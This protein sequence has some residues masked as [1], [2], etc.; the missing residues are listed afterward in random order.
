MK[1][2]KI[3]ILKKKHFIIGQKRTER[4]MPLGSAIEHGHFASVHTDNPVTPI[5]SFRPVKAAIT[6][7][8]RT[9]SQVIGEHEK[10]SIIN[11]LKTIT[12][13]PAWQ[14]FEEDNIGSIEI[15]KA[16]DFVLID[17]NPLEID[18]HELDQ[19]EIFST[20][21]DGNK[22]NTSYLTWTNFKLAILATLEMFLM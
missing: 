3:F 4:Y 17:K 5:D 20:W 8:A 2:K 10:L 7:K 9:N 14:F 21:I 18:P 22:I 6:R 15:G 1:I 19:I 11:A 16:A 12:I 13:F